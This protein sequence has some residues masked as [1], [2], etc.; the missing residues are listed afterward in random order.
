MAVIQELREEIGRIK[1]TQTRMEGDIKKIKEALA[2]VSCRVVS[3]LG[4][5]G[6]LQCGSMSRG[7][8]LGSLDCVGSPGAFHAAE[9]P[10]HKDNM[11]CVP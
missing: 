2:L 7:V 9:G 5:H 11:R 6:E 10:P 3:S 1:A 8:G 4:S